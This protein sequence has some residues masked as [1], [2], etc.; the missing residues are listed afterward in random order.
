MSCDFFMILM[1]PLICM[2]Y[3]Y[4]YILFEFRK[5]IRMRKNLRDVID[6]KETDNLH[7]ITNIAETISVVSWDT[8]EW[9]SAVSLTWRSQICGI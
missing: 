8:A 7:R 4:S 3:K 9:R 1:G 6:I 5:D 2:Y